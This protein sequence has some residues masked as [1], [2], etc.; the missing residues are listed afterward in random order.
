MYVLLPGKQRVPSL[1]GP[2]KYI[3]WGWMGSSAKAM[4]CG[5]LRILDIYSSMH[6][7]LISYE[8]AS[9]VT[10]V[11]SGLIIFFHYCLLLKCN[12]K[13]TMLKEVIR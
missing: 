5:T 4:H 11:L 6:D 9:G 7:Q 12:E 1:A 8:V 13:G 10:Q 2:D 3:E